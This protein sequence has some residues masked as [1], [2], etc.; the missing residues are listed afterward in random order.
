MTL[1]DSERDAGRG[2]N[3]ARQVLA[4]C[5]QVLARWRS[6]GL[7]LALC[8]PSVGLVLALCWPCVGLVLA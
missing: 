3:D 2:D 4:R 1:S 8:L 6:V 5:S 7:V